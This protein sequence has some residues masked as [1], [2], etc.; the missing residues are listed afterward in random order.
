MSGKSL[1]ESLMITA[2]GSIRAFSELCG[3]PQ[4]TITS[5]LKR[6]ESATVQNAIKISRALGVGLEI[7]DD[8]SETRALGA[9]ELALLKDYRTSSPNTQKIVRA[10]VDAAKEFKMESGQQIGIIMGAEVDELRD[11]VDNAIEK[12]EST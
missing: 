8:G 3:V 2:C 5:I 7:F 4:S 10:V 1:L 12:H 9:D 11:R 6:P